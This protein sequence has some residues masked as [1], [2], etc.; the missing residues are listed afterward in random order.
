[1]QRILWRF[2]RQTDPNAVTVAIDRH[3]GC[4]RCYRRIDL[5]FRRRNPPLRPAV[6]RDSQPEKE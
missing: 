1:M 3:V 2:E 5:R 4:R 6:N